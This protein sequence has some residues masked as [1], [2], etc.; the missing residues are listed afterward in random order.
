MACVTLRTSMGDLYAEN[1]TG[2][3]MLTLLGAEGR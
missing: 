1:S 2:K 3:L